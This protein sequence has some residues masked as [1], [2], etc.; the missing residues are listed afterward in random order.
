MKNASL[1]VAVIKKQVGTQARPIAAHFEDIECFLL[2]D[3][4]KALFRLFEVDKVPARPGGREVIPHPVRRSGRKGYR[5]V[6]P[7]WLPNSGALQVESPEWSFR[8][9]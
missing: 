7:S 8:P 4:G 5:T 2:K 9:L 1:R 3:R 6:L